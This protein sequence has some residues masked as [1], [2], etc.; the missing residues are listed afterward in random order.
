MI[1]GPVGVAMLRRW[2]KAADLSGA[3]LGGTRCGLRDCAQ[4]TSESSSDLESKR[5]LEQ[6]PRHLALCLASSPCMQ[7]DATQRANQK[8]KIPLRHVPPLLACCDCGRDCNG[9][10]G[11]MQLAHQWLGKRCSSLCCGGFLRR[12]ISSGAQTEEQK[13]RVLRPATNQCKD[14][15]LDM[16]GRKITMTR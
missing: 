9:E 2:K 16:G 12:L 8:R 3:F 13:Q 7:E 11:K 15:T 10:E 4:S 5:E 14:A 6:H 1:T